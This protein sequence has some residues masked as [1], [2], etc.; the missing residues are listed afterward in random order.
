M[1]NDDLI[2]RSY[3]NNVG[4]LSLV[5]LQ[6]I[7]PAVDIKEKWLHVIYHSINDWIYSGVRNLIVNAPPRLGKSTM[8]SRMLPIALLVNNPQLKIVI[9]IANSKARKDCSDKISSILNK[10][11]SLLHQINP[12]FQLKR[13]N[14]EEKTTTLGGHI[15]IVPARSDITGTGANYMFFDDFL[16]PTELKRREY[17]TS[18]DYLTMFFTRREYS[19]MTKYCIIEQ[20]IH[21]QDITGLL[22][23]R[24]SHPTVRQE[25]LHVSLPYQFP[26]E[27]TFTFKKTKI[28][29]TQNEFLS[30]RFNE[31]DM[32]TIKS[33]FNPQDREKI[34][35]TQYL[36]KPLPD[37]DGVLWSY[38][39]IVEANNHDFNDRNLQEIKNMMV[40]IVIGV[41]PAITG[42]GDETG[43]VVCGYDGSKYYILEDHSRRYKEPLEWARM[44]SIIYEKWDA[45][46]VI[47]ETNQGGDLNI[48]ILKTANDRMY[49]R[50]ERA[51]VGK[52]VR[53][54]PISVLYGLKKV[55][56]IH[57]YNDYTTKGLQSLE[58]QML[59]YNGIDNQSSP[60]R[61]DACVYA[62]Q[63]LDNRYNKK[64]LRL[65]K[66]NI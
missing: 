10:K 3:R 40:E 64:V 41:D 49:I 30:A 55:L 27:T 44:V 59:T 65:T 32:F 34:W 19:P 28:N 46:C 33:N 63:Y 66:L 54:E 23:D 37:T 21:L 13:D 2:I 31:V 29:F 42:T 61:L 60:D 51:R 5:L 16:K 26:E 7:E 36:Q 9:I 50:Q 18:Q 43:I 22:I 4:F 11:M 58:N 56:H 52:M 48:S 6:C 39:M 12:A 47:V 14:Q 8:L 25:F 20:R 45:R 62:I 15:K 17:I 24:W 53:A 57:T 38:D 1:N 35:S